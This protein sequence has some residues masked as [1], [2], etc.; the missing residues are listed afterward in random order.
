MK[1]TPIGKLGSFGV[2][3]DD[4]DWKNIT[5]EEWVEI[6]KLWVKEL[7]VV[8][9]NV[10][11]NKSDFLDRIPKFGPIKVNSRANL[12]QK[13][14]KE[15]NTVDSSTWGNIDPK[16]RELL[17]T[18]MNL[19]EET[20]DGRLITRAYGHR[21][22]QGRAL[23][24]FSHG[25]VY[26]HSNESS[27]LTFAPGVAFFGWN[28][29]KGSATSFVQSVDFY[30]NITESFRSELNEMVMVHR[31][32]PGKLNDN[33][34]FDE[35]LSHMIR[36]SFCPKDDAE[37][38]LV[39]QAPNGR[40]GLH[41]TVNS[42]SYIKGTTME[43]SQRIFDELDQLILNDKWIYDHWWP[44]HTE[45]R[46]VCLFDNSVT[47]HRRLG[48]PKDRKGFRIQVD[49]STCIDKPW[50]PWIHMPEYHDKYL[51]E[52]KNLVDLF[53]GELKQRF[54]MPDGIPA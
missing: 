32:T 2:Y 31:Y 8:L 30:E 38:P 21:D 41:Y 43:E 53:G 40:R 16:D 29:V 39:C 25:D 10:P 3:V 5:D 18:K 23:G 12:V 50:T 13:Y 11:W 37:T 45:Q 14:G 24:Y 42:R 9:R 15:F 34:H 20:E 47:L 48:G 1:I 35:Y 26:W 49:L 46:D 27:Q 7:V 19:M 44:D 17:E 33:E 22:E 6:G 28:D 51:V 36:M 4:I 52:I 54:K